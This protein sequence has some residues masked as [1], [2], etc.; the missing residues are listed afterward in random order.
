MPHH[1]R[2]WG[3]PSPGHT[4]LSSND[5]TYRAVTRRRFASHIPFVAPYYHH[6]AS[7]SVEGGKVDV[8]LITGANNQAG[9]GVSRML[10]MGK[11]WA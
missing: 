6:L 4:H 5:S 11:E 10:L 2:A 8:G 7:E 3:S 9:K 1:P